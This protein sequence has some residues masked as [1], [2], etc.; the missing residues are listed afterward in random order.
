MADA[1][2]APAP[3]GLG[4]VPVPAPGNCNATQIAYLNYFRVAML[5]ALAPI[6][7]TNS[8][9]GAFLLEW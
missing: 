9:H 6:L 3:M 5:S 1:A 7:A 8:P 2:Q 4:C